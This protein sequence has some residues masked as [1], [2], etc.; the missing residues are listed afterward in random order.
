[1]SFIDTIIRDQWQPNAGLLIRNLIYEY[2][3]VLGLIIRLCHSK[4]ALVGE[5]ECD[6]G[7]GSV[8]GGSY[9]FHTP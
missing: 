3:W 6:E 7:G 2:T 1:V 8:A 9:M 4:Q 5:G